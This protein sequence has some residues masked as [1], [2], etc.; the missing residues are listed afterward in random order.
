MIQ[1]AYLANSNPT[2]PIPTQMLSPLDDLAQ[3]SCTMLERKR[4][5]IPGQIE[6]SC[7]A[8]EF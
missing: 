4:W 2:Q 8:P 6:S 1:P 5:S 3:P 7:K